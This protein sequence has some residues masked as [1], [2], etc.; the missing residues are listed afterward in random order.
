MARTHPPSAP[1]Y[2]R[3]VSEIPD[4]PSSG[5]APSSEAPALA[6]RERRRFLFNRWVDL[7]GLG[8]GSLFVL[9][10]FAA[11][12]PEDDEAL[13]AL[14]IGTAVVANFVNHPLSPTPTSSSTTAS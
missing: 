1:E 5:R 6:T 10:A 2:R 4:V 12:Y 9:A 3:S 7:L 14:L 8:G 11:L 13:T